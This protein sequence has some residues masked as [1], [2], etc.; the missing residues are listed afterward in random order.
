MS[1][2]RSLQSPADITVART[3]MDDEPLM[4]SDTRLIKSRTIAANGSF[5]FHFDKLATNHL[6]CP[7]DPRLSPPVPTYAQQH[8]IA[9]PVS[10]KHGDKAPKNCAS[11]CL[12]AI[13]QLQ[14]LYMKAQSL[15]GATAAL[16]LCLLK[17]AYA[18]QPAAPCHPNPNAA[19][20]RQTVGTRG[21]IAGLPD[22]LKDRLVQLADR[23][24]TFLPMQVF[25]EADKPGQ[26][27]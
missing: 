16:A 5:S 12:I 10:S 3:R 1:D 13:K 9:D 19:A 14:E 17:N 7:S 27:V 24:H 6:I 8:L 20:D 22:P 2:D 23:P 18:E 26:L 15:I 25:A 4:V 21:D 11:T